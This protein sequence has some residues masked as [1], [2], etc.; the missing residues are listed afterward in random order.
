MMG[1]A[2]IGSNGRVKA[3]EPE[4]LVETLARTTRYPAQVNKAELGR[5]PPDG[6]VISYDGGSGG[7]FCG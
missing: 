5:G 6:R 7:W 1:R 3:T 2:A 4:K